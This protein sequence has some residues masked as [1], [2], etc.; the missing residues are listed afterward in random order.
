[1]VMNETKY[2]EKILAFLDILGFERLVNESR[3]NP[4]LINRIASILARSKENAAAILSTK[5]NVLRVC[6][7]QYTHRVFSDTS[8]ITGPYTSHDDVIFLFWWIMRYQYLLWK[9]ERTFVRGAIV[10][11]EIYE[12]AD[13]IF[14]PALIDAYRLENY[15]E[16]N[17]P[18][19]PRVLIDKSLLEKSTE[20]ERR[21]DFF[22]FL[23]LDEDNHIA[24]LDYLRELFHLF[25]VGAYSG[26]IG[27]LFGMKSAGCSEQIGHPL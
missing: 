8:V 22:E 27:R 18:A 4:L 14:G 9:E 26:E 3:S 24:Y 23:A 5:L 20:L 21:R 13:V 15:K 16:K 6:P 10:Y 7:A 25:V 19:W 1:M 12:N 11:G 2:T 17:K